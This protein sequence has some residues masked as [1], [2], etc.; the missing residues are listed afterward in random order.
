MGWQKGKERLLGSDL[1]LTFPLCAPLVAQTSNKPRNTWWKYFFSGLKVRVNKLKAKR[2]CVSVGPEEILGF[3]ALLC[4]WL[5]A[6]ILGFH[7]QMVKFSTL[8]SSPWS[9]ISRGSFEAWNELSVTRFC[10]ELLWRKRMR[11][12]FWLFLQP[13]S[14]PQVIKCL[15][16]VPGALMEC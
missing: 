4:P 9:C 15:K 13:L 14:T 7:Q 6:G 10:V 12:Q 1:K 16:L 3:R 5:E 11:S 8:Q 2:W